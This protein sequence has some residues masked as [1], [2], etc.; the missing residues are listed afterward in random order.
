[1]VNSMEE[2]QTI[3]N[4]TIMGSS[5]STLGN[6]YRGTTNTKSKEVSAP[7]IPHVHS[8]II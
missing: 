1:M 6:I 5:N 2:P 3:K 4:R 7:L 8:K